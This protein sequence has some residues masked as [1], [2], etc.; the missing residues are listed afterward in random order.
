MLSLAQAQDRAQSLVDAARKAGA[1]A[2]DALYVCNASTGV[3][4]RLGE[5][6]D[7]EQSEGEEIGL[8]IFVGSRSATVSASDLERDSLNALVDR[9]LAMAKEAPEDP[10]ATLAPQELLMKSKPAALDIV[11]EAAPDPATLKERALIVEDAACSVPGITNSEGGGASMGRSQ[12]ALATSH[13]F[14]EA[15]P[16][17]RTAHGRAY[18]RARAPACSAIMPATAPAISKIWKTRSISERGQANARL[19]DW[20]RPRSR[21]DRCR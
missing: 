12:V 7:I 2:A 4:V 3:S 8:R 13:G 10:Y 14:A 5:M 6:E 21:A 18:W 19:P 9:C 11:D 20:A 16:P 17:P 15:T 1:D